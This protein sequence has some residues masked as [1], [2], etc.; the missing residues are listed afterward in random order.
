VLLGDETGKIRLTLWNDMARM[1][2]AKGETISHKRL[3]AGKYG[4]LEIQT[5]SGTV[6]RKSSQQVDFSEKITAHSRLKQA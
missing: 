2:L 5:G 3:L 1:P 4:S 6:V